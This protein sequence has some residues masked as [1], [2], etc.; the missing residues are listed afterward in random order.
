[1]NK[2]PKVL[3]IKPQGL[4]AEYVVSET[5]EESGGTT[6]FK[7]KVFFSIHVSDENI[8]NYLK[9]TIN[10]ICDI[11]SIFNAYQYSDNLIENINKSKDL[12]L[13]KQFQLGSPMKQL[14]QKNDVAPVHVLTNQ[15][16]K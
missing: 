12:Y 15:N 3:I 5:G 13:N 4:E 7:P 9:K 14:T 2:T 11:E 8:F 16:K 6:S 10:P 1:M